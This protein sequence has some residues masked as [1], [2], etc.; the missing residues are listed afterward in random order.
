MILGFKTH[1]KNR[2][3][4]F[5]PKIYASVGMLSDNFFLPKV[6]TIRKGNRFKAGTKLHMAIG[7]RTKFYQQ[8]NRCITRLE[9]CISVQRIEII[10]VNDQ[11]NSE[12]E[13][14]CIWVHGIYVPSIKET[15]YNVFMVKVDGRFLST[16]EIEVL[17]VNDGF[18]NTDDFFNWFNEDF[19][20]QIIHWTN[21]RY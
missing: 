20:G 19:E 12:K 4:Y 11:Y 21:F 17:A 9:R 3:T 16:P 18:E 14:N 10:K 8:F 13:S 2:P 5:I 1:I 15:F 6:H 7:V